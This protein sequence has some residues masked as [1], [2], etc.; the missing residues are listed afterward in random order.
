PEGASGYPDRGMSERIVNVREIML[1]DV[2]TVT[3]QASVDEVA[4]LMLEGGLASVPVVENGRLLGVVTETDLVTK[5]ARVHMPTYL[6]ILGTVIPFE[7]RGT[8]EEI[9]RVLAVTAGELMEREAPTIGPDAT[10]EDV[11]TYMVDEGVNPVAVV[12]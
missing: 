7:R 2:R 12:D 8:D 5:H 10:V 3:P 6:G 1:S 11:A 9:R 4:R